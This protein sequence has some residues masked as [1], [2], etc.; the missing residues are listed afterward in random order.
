MTSSFIYCDFD[1]LLL[2]YSLVCI[3]NKWGSR[4]KALLYKTI[5]PIYFCVFLRLGLEYIALQS[6]HKKSSFGIWDICIYI[7]GT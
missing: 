1:G 4:F 5:L 3:E 2:V 7:E 6:H